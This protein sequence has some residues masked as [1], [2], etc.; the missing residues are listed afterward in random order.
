MPHP[1]FNPHDVYTSIDIHLSQCTKL[2]RHDREDLRQE[3]ILAVMERSSEYDPALA[4][5]STFLDRIVRSYIE[6]FL[7]NLRW[8]KNQSPESLEEIAENE[9]QRIPRLN[10]V[11][12]WELNVQENSFFACEVREMIDVMPKRLRTLAE[13]LQHYSPAETA[14]MM[15]VASNALQHDIKKLKE[16]FEK[17]NMRPFHFG[18]I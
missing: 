11:S 8:Q 12:S 2:H 9:P 3:I 1:E 7:L 14:D 4:S 13:H 18:E 17:A 16:I 10:D 6:G 5:W 15:G